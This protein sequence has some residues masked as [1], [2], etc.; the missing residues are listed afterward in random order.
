MGGGERGDLEKENREGNQYEWR[1][2][3]GAPEL[4]SLILNPR[5]LHDCVVRTGKTG[6][7]K[8]KRNATFGMPLIFKLKRFLSMFLEETIT[9]FPSAS[10]PLYS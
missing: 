7:A 5:G 4:P 1:Q 8:M 9:G 3:R 2:I 6:E 10:Q